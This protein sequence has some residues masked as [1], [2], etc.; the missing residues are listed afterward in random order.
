MG[1]AINGLS[2]RKADS[3]ERYPGH[4]M[5]IREVSRRRTVRAATALDFARSSQ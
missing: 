4:Y 2:K 5:L 1:N 3:L